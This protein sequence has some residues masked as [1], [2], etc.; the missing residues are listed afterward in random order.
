MFNFDTIIKKGKYTFKIVNNKIQDC[1]ITKLSAVN[2][3]AIVKHLLPLIETQIKNIKPSLNFDTLVKEINYL[4]EGLD[5]VKS[6]KRVNCSYGSKSYEEVSDKCRSLRYVFHTK[7]KEEK[8]SPAEYLTSKWL[9]GFDTNIASYDIQDLY[10]PVT[11]DKSK[12]KKWWKD[13]NSFNYKKYG[14]N[15]NKVIEGEGYYDAYY[16]HSSPKKIYHRIVSLIDNFKIILNE[17]GDDIIN[18]S[19]QKISLRFTKLG[20]KCKAWDIGNYLSLYKEHLQRQGVKPVDKKKT[21][22]KGKLEDLVENG[23]PTQDDYFRYYKQMSGYQASNIIK[24]LDLEHLYKIVDSK[25]K[26]VTKKLVD[27][28]GRFGEDAVKIAERLCELSVTQEDY[29]KIINWASTDNVT[30]DFMIKHK[31]HTNTKDVM[32]F[33]FYHRLSTRE[34]IDEDFYNTCLA[35]IPKNKKFKLDE[36]LT[37]Q[38]MI[39]MDDS[40]RVATLKKIAIDDSIEVNYHTLNEL[41]DQVDYNLIRDIILKNVDL[42]QHLSLKIAKENDTEGM[43][44]S[45]KKCCD[46]LS[47]TQKKAIF[48]KLTYEEKKEVIL[49]DVQDEQD[50]YRQA[51]TG[52]ISQLSDSENIDLLQAIIEKQRSNNYALKIFK[53]FYEGKKIKSLARANEVVRKMVNVNHLTHEIIPYLTVDTKVELLKKG[54]DLKDNTIYYSYH[55]TTRVISNSLGTAFFQDF[56]RKD[57][58]KV[59]SSPVSSPYRKF[60]GHTM[61]REELEKCALSEIANWNFGGTDNRT[62]EN[63]FFR[64]NLDLFSYGFLKQFKEKEKFRTVVGDRRN[65]TNRYF[66]EKL[67]EKLNVTNSLDFMF[68]D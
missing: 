41:F 16:M 39:R 56:K 36:G 2:A 65:S 60:L 48:D 64:Y 49:Y 63:S 68:S 38:Y 15:K 14:V 18:W 46:N 3:N 5:L 67:L 42:L 26:C 21:T 55:N 10:N 62:L 59:T 43:L 37:W 54:I 45:A 8:Y 40:E 32:S 25:L 22:S 7:I 35:K 17:A 57:I 61:T 28:W 58:D 34:I 11:D 51:Y 29:T 66:G 52:A 13:L 44:E 33:C 53:H 47:D 31:D 4:M 50:Y 9:L 19:D 20:V 23:D 27:K 6:V 1:E 12:L 24:K 30:L